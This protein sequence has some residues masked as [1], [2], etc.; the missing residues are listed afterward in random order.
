[1]ARVPECI[2]ITISDSTGNAGG[3]ACD[4]DSE[5][6][7]GAN[8]IADN[9]L[10]SRDIPMDCGDRQESFAVPHGRLGTS[11]AGGLLALDRIT[12]PIVNDRLVIATT[13][14]LHLVAEVVGDVAIHSDRDSLL[15]RRYRQYSGAFVVPDPVLGAQPRLSPSGA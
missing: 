2:S 11:W 5:C 13:S 4:R 9:F 6:Q 3:I 1:M 10:G 12:Q 15:A 14:L 8:G 7:A